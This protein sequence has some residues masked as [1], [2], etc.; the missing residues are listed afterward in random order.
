LRDRALRAL[1]R[2]RTGGLV[3]LIYLARRLIDADRCGIPELDRIAE[4]LEELREATD[5]GPPDGDA[6]IESDRA[7]SL[8]LVRAECIRLA[9]ALDG[10]GVTTESIR[11][12]YDLAAH[13]PLPEVRDAVRDVTDN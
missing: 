7:V 5:Y 3:H 8:P 11:M 1:E 2:G 12:W 9:R 6:D 4:V 13:D 10:K